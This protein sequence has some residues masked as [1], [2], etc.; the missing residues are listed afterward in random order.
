MEIT[1]F[2][3]REKVR[4]QKIIIDNTLG[5]HKIRTR[6]HLELH[7]KL[8]SLAEETNCYKYWID[9]DSSV[10]KSKIFQKYLDCFNLIINMGIY[11]N[12]DYIKDV[13]IKPNDYCLS[14]QFLNLFID[15]NDLI[16]SPSEDHYI[17]LMEDFLSLGVTLGYSENQMKEALIG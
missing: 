2:F 12:Y 5:D 3:Q 10:D 11:K 6:K 8:S 17:T 9:E 7:S 15:L 13:V 1:S 14:D 4:S 16:I